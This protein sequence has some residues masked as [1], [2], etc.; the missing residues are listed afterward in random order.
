MKDLFS[1]KGYNAASMEE[2]CRVTG[3]S[4]GSIYYHFKSKEEMFMY[5]IKL[6]NEEWM[7]AWMA[8]E[9]AYV[10]TREKLFALADHYVDDM[11]NPLTHAVNE[12]MSSQVVTEDM[13]NDMLEVTRLPYKAY[14]QLI[15]RG[16]ERG[17]LKKDS[18]SDIMYVLNGLINGMSTL[19]FEKDLEE[20]RRLYKKGIE[21]LLT[22]IEAPTE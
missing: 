13:L 22:G 6:N 15:I 17:E 9:A 20:I 18:S 14:E 21:I 7:E 19:Y 2:V 1:Q 4:K 10:T 16:M 5:L 3:R 8:K 12:F 11:N